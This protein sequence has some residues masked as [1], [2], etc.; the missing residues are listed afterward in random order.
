M[1]RKRKGAGKGQPAR[2][3]SNASPVRLIGKALASPLDL[4]GAPHIFQ[5]E[6]KVVINSVICYNPHRLS[7]QTELAWGKGY[8]V[9]G[10]GVHVG[11]RK[12]KIQACPVKEK[13]GPSSPTM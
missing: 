4:G 3:P 12:I 13:G 10:G 2:R 6:R 9:L 7:G 5:R 11:W 1:S 8:L